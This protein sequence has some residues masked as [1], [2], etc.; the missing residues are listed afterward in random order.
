MQG[1]ADEADGYIRRR[2]QMN[3]DRSRKQEADLQENADEC[4]R[5]RM[6]AGERG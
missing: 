4:R 6:N 1:N 5:T 3:A 2:T